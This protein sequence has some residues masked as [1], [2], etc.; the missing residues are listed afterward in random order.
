MSL[1]VD[2]NM[3]ALS[4]WTR[5]LPYVNLIRQGRKWGTAD[6]PFNG[7]ATIDPATG[8]PTCDFGV[9]LASLNLDLGGTY[10]FR[11]IGNASI[12]NW[13]GTVEQTYDPLTNT[14]TT[15]RT[16]PV[17][18]DGIVIVFRNTT[19]PG[20]RNIGLLQPGYNLSRASD[21][22]DLFLAHLSCFNVIRFID[23]TSTNNNFET[24]ESDNT[25]RLANIC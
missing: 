1:P 10:L 22:T 2:G 3:D 18:T 9:I 24:L 4:D 8:W 7:N 21:F 17:G 19:G 12:T 13:D 5:T 15:N 20:L 23:W 16:M 6:N 11:A 14:M 25:S